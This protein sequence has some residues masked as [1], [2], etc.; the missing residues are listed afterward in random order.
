MILKPL[1]EVCKEIQQ[2]YENLLRILILT[3]TALFRSKSL[4]ISCRMWKKRSYKVELILN[5]RPSTLI[6][7][8]YSS[9]KLLHEVDLLVFKLTLKFLTFWDFLKNIDVNAKNKETMLKHE[10][11]D[12]NLKN[13]YERKH[14]DKKIISRLPRNKNFRTLRR[15][16]KL[17]SLNFLKLGITIWATTKQLRILVLKSWK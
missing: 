15:L 3:E 10:R 7:N 1:W 14:R 5:N 17:N 4:S 2:K 8:S 13:S 6:P 12:L 9:N 11:H 16:K